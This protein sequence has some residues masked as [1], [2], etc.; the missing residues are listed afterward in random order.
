VLVVAKIFCHRQC[1]MSDSKAATWWFVHLT[2]DHSHIWQNTGRL[3]IPV[4]F[5]TLAAALT[6]AAEDTHALVMLDRVVDHLTEQHGFADAGT[7]K[8]SC[9]PAALKR[10]Q[11]I[12]DL[13]TGLKNF[14]LR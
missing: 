3:H 7:A 5:F 11:H 14:G 6:D 1:G 9:L 4:K 12:D 8:Q 10:H 2:K 13:D